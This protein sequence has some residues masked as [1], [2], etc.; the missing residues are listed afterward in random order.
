MQIHFFCRGIPDTN[1][2]YA[3]VERRAAF[4][5]DRFTDRIRR[6]WVRLRDDNGPRGGTDKRCSVVVE[7]VR[8][9][10]LCFVDDAADP[11][12]VVDRVLDRASRTLA[13]VIDR[14]R[15]R[16]GRTP[17]GGPEL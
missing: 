5:L 14:R 7:M 8:G 11:R 12:T 3:H 2:L 13:R 9:P 4:S 17:T 10:R 1:G 15:D 6:L 16:S